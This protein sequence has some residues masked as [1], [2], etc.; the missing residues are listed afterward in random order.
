MAWFS[1]VMINFFLIGCRGSEAPP[2][3][4]PD[5]HADEVWGARYFPNV[6]LTTHEGQKVHFFD[7][8]IK[9]KVVAV[10]F[11]YTSCPDACPM[12]TA[13]LLE[14]Q[15]LLADRMGKDIFFYSISI[16][17][18]HDTPEV[19]NGY[20]KQWGIGPGWTFLTGKM[21]DIQ[22]LRTKL[23][24]L[25]MDEDKGKPKDHNLSVTIGNQKTGRWMKRSPF[26]NP[27]VLANQLG[28][29]LSNWKAPSNGASYAEAPELRPLSTGEDLFRTRCAACH[30]IGGGDTSIPA[31]RRVGPDLYHV[32]RTRK[33]E[34]LQRWLAEPD[35]MLEEGDPIATQLMTQY[36]GVRMPNLRLSS[37]DI[38]S[39]LS[40]LDTESARVDGALE[41][42]HANPVVEGHPPAKPSEG[43][44]P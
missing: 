31:E 9:D 6:E 22:L 15:R 5:G 3:K 11:I 20:M 8:L 2:P 29:W 28:S 26:E 16:D 19:L 24:V 4:E 33:K 32:G 1:V 44:T 17:P 13:R 21:E 14:V 30:T 25:S 7:D 10:N 39:L 40:F 43:S 41:A 36:Q 18:E 42:Q 23:G 12:E 27:Y 35:K 38:E 37:V 34:W